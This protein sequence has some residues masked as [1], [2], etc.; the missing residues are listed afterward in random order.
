[1]KPPC[2]SWPCLLTGCQ[3][4]PGRSQCSSP[5]AVFPK[6]QLGPRFS[7]PAPLSKPP[8]F[9]LL[10]PAAV[11]ELRGRRRA[12]LLALDT[13]E[14]SWRR[15]ARASIHRRAERSWEKL[16][17]GT[18]TA[19][20]SSTAEASSSSRVPLPLCT[21]HA[22]CRAHG[23]VS[24]REAGPPWQAL[25][26]KGQGSRRMVLPGAVGPRWLPTPGCFCK[27]TETFLAP[28]VMP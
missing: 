23:G 8:P 11:R 19:G 22:S 20:Y 28:P 21:H 9:C 1:M 17:G 7:G 12:W 16:A 5:H 27:R 14:G 2:G 6:Q 25:D 10:P 3:L 24:P 4:Q 18:D 15:G 26:A 13:Q